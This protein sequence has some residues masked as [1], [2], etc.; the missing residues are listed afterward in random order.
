MS[1]HYLQELAEAFSADTCSAGE[2]CAPLK[3]TPSVG[4]RCLDVKWMDA[5]LSSLSGMTSAPST[6]SLGAGLLTSS[7]VGS[8]AKTFPLLEKGPESKVNDPDC[9]GIWHESFVRYDPDTSTWRTHRCLFDEDLLWSSVTLPKWGSMH[10]GVC[11]A[12]TM[13]EVRIDGRGSGFWATPTV[14]CAT[15]GQTSRGGDRSGE[16]L[17]SG[18]AKQWPTP[19]SS[20]S[21]PDYARA[22]RPESGGDDTATAVARSTPWALNPDWV[23]WLMAWPIGWT[24]LNPLATVR[25]RSWLQLHGLF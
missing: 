19:K 14:A 4:R 1:W 21:G 17:L 25:F 11:W 10:G 23:E 22:N 3:S 12:L 8:L 16:L 24:D 13:S 5:Y 15:G 20:P 18:Q 6:A 9:G 7:P 2:Q